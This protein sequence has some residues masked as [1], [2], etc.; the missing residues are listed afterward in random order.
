MSRPRPQPIR[1]HHDR[2]ADLAAL[3]A[4]RLIRSRVRVSPTVAFVMADAAGLIREA[5]HG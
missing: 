5:R 4:V 3:L 1:I 2:D